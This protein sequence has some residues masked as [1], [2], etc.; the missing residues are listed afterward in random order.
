M[1]VSGS[2]DL[3]AARDRVWV[4]LRD[5]AVL[6]RALPGCRSLER[7]ARD[8]YA[9]T[10]AAAVA[11]IRG[12]F[13]GTVSLRDLD[14][15]TAYTVHAT[16]QGAPGTLEATA[17]VR[18]ADLRGGGTRV[19]YDAEAVVGGT[20]AGVGQRVLVAAAQRHA[21][22]FFSGIDAAL[23]APLAEPEEAPRGPRRGLDPASMA[24]GVALALAGVLA[25]RWF[26]R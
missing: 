20:I 1:N 26:R 6:T 22:E 8:T 23:T 14:P 12:L 21:E 10:M 24:V 16:G 7:T 25:G 17:R 18:L 9:V 15:P 13:T 2:H 11:S 3:A 19:T 5:P 4:A